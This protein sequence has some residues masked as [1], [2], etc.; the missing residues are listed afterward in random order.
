MARLSLARLECLRI[1]S[2]IDDEP[3]LISPVAD[4]AGYAHVPDALKI[5]EDDEER[6]AGGGIGPQVIEHRDGVAR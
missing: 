3:D 4:G 1:T 2:A 5:G 6:L